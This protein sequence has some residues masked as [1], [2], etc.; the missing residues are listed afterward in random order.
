MWQG[1]AEFLAVVEKGSFTSAAKSLDVSVS[2]ISRHVASLE[3]RLGCSLLNRSTRKVALTD[4]GR[5]YATQLSAIRDALEDA[6]VRMQGH[7]QEPQGLIRISGA[8][9][10]VANQVAPSIADFLTRYPK[11]SIEMDFN[12]RNVDLVEEGYD[13]AI[14][15]GR[16]KDSNLIAKPLVNRPMCVVASPAYLQKSSPITAPEHLS[17]HNCLV[18]VNNRWRFKLGHTIQD[19]KVSGNWRSNHADAIIHA[20]IKGLGVAYLAEDLIQQHLATRTLVEVLAQYRVSDNATWLVYP[21][22]DLMPHRVRLLI[23]HLSDDF[24]R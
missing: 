7:A 12:N 1:L 11:V 21:R 14:R 4:E 20:A 6:T 15:F 17:Q 8:G 16:L 18:A 22:R 24:V 10:F 9:G 5:M 19:V 23:N 2:H 3:S 13:L